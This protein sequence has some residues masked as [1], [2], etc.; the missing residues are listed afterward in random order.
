M[1]IK[2]LFLHPVTIWGLR[3]VVAAVLLYAGFQKAWMPL[4]F[5][6]LLKQYKIVPDQ[7]LNLVAVVLPWS[8]IICGFC[9]LSGLWIKGAAVFL[10]GMNAIFIFAISYRSWLIMSTTNTAFLDLSFDCGCGF[11]VVYIP[12]KILENFILVVI[13]IIILL[14][15]F[16][17]RHE[18]RYSP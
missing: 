1:S 4:E 15:R 16:E 6:R 18:G 12:T 5:A 17:S 14:S 10:S 13:G 7:F 9:F 2:R 8:E 3:L 11:G